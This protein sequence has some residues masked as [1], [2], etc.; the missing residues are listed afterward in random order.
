MRGHLPMLR[1]QLALVALASASELDC[2][3]S[4]IFDTVLHFEQS[5]ISLNNLGGLGDSG[6]STQALIFANAGSTGSQVTEVPA[7]TDFDIMIFNTSEYAPINYA[8]TGLNGQFAQI[9]MDSP[10]D[11]DTPYAISG[12]DE[13]VAT[14]KVC[15]VE[16]GT[17]STA[18]PTYL[19]LD[20][21]P[22]TFYDLCARFAARPKSPCAPNAHGSAIAPSLASQ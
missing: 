21:L 4:G 8:N 20:H 3:P 13:Q 2:L 9:N 15:A 17:G 1:L 22:L 19:T 11:G 12:T 6:E 10:R 14:F 16:H 5:Y 18:N 7:G